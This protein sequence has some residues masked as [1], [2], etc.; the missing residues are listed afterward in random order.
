MNRHPFIRWILL[1]LLLCLLSSALTVAVIYW[2]HTV[3]LSETSEVYRQYR[4]QPGVRAAFIRQMP[5][6]DTLRL[7]MTL[8]EAEDSAAFADLLRAMGKSEEKIDEMMLMRRIYGKRENGHEIRFTGDCVRGA[9][10][11]PGGPDPN[12]NEIVSYFPVRMCVAVIHTHTE[13]EIELVFHK[14]LFNEINIDKH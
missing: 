9:P 14:S 11:V 7:D 10:G 1:T 12:N 13:Q 8:L 4:H 2:R 3:P 5:I 6:N